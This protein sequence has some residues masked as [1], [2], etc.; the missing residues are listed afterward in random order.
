MAEETNLSGH[1]QDGKRLHPPFAKLKGM[2]LTSWKD[3]AIPRF[4]GQL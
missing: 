3:L 2:Q 1:S 4:Y